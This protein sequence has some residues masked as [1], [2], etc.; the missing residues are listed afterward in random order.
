MNDVC[1]SFFDGPSSPVSANLDIVKLEEKI[2]LI[3]NWTMGLYQLGGTAI[4]RVHASK[5]LVRGTK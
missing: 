4:R 5:A 1:R 3:L 2:N